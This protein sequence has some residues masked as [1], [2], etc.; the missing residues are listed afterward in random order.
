MHYNHNTV[1][2]ARTPRRRLSLSF[3]HGSSKT[4]ST[5]TLSRSELQRVVAEMVG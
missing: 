1:S 2:A 3:A 4:P 5:P